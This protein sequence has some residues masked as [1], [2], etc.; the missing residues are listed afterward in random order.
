MAIRPKASGKSRRVRIRLL[1]SCRPFCTPKPPI[2]QKLPEIVLWS[3]MECRRC[4]SLTIMEFEFLLLTH[5][6][7]GII[8]DQGCAYRR[9]LWSTQCYIRRPIHG[10]DDYAST[11]GV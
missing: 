7:R 9:V 1:T 10:V 3:F 6:K 4:L 5:N 2:T 11:Y 8:T